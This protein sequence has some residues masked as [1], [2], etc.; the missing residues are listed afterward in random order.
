V[1]RWFLR[2]GSPR[3][4]I[5]FGVVIVALGSAEGDWEGYALIG[6]GVVSIVLGVLTLHRR[7][8][9]DPSSG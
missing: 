6:I 7:R 5:A 9:A 3:W 1:R 2:V 8:F 4:N